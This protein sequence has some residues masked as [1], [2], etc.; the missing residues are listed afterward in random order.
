MI[1]ITQ[2]T[3]A[4]E[5]ADDEIL[6]KA[7]MSSRLGLLTEAARLTAGDRNKDYG[8][9]VENHRHIAEIFNAITGI[10][11][12]ARNV[13]M[14]HVATKLARMKTSP[15]KSDSYVDAMAYLGIAYE[16]EEAEK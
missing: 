10:Q 3:I 13:A 14:L 6:S 16:C 11:I 15:L 4:D 7:A 2:K 8:S 1:D 5:L 9:P 12:S